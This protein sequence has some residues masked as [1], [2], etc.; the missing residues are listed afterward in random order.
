MPNDHS[1]PSA[2]CEADSILCGRN[3]GADLLC[4]YERCLWQGSVRELL[5]R[6]PTRVT[7]LAMAPEGQ[8]VVAASW[9]GTIRV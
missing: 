8:P 3:L 6:L 1:G 5:M 2:R 4:L 9:D 7:G